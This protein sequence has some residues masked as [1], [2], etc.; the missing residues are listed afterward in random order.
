MLDIER[1][2]KSGLPGKI[3]MDNYFDDDDKITDLMLNKNTNGNR[4]EITKVDGSDEL[5]GNNGVKY[6]IDNGHYNNNNNKLCVDK[7]NLCFKYVRYLYDDG[8]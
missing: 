6:Y 4:I 5:M 7:N 1:D 2:E 8:G 3:E